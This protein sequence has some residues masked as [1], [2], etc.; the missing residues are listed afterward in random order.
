MPF[1]VASSD[2]PYIKPCIQIMHVLK[3]FIYLSSDWTQGV[4]EYS[5]YISTISIEEQ[6]K[7]SLLLKRSSYIFGAYSLPLYKAEL[8]GV[9]QTIP[10]PGPG[11]RRRGVPTVTTRT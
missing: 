7:L 9:M 11:K 2:Y 6:R 4:T 3:V 8:R 10:V 5:V 1:V